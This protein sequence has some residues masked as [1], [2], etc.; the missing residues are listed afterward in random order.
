M[1]KNPEPRSVF[2]A[3]LMTHQYAMVDEDL[4]ELFKAISDLT[5]A[6]I[7]A[8][9]FSDDEPEPS[10][11]TLMGDVAY[12]SIKGPLVDH[13]DG[14]DRMMG[15]VSCDDLRTQLV[16]ARTD[17]AVSRV[18]LQVDSPG[19]MVDGLSEVVNAIKA[20]GKPIVAHVEGTC[21]SAAYWISSAC[22]AIYAAVT[23]RVG[24]LGAILTMR[25]RSTAGQIT[26]TSSQSPLKNASLEST[27]GRAVYQNVVD[28]LADVF[29]TSVALNRGI[30][31]ADVLE[32][33]G[34]GAIFAAA[35]A[36]EAGMID[37]LLGVTDEM[38]EQLK[39][40]LA[41]I[42]VLKAQNKEAT[43]ALAAE[44]ARAL[45]LEA[46]QAQAATEAAQA[47]AERDALKSSTELLTEQLKAANELKAKADAERAKV[48]AEAFETAATAAVEKLVTDSKITAAA[49][50]VWRRLY[51]LKK[52]DPQSTVFEDTAETL[53]GG[54][55][56]YDPQGHGD[57]DAP[58]SDSDKA[59]ALAKEKGISFDQAYAK[60]RGLGL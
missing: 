5:E 51:D 20:L 48:E 44:Q 13:A 11:Y 19:G 10:T 40:A 15:L 54:V 43:D 32:N 53:P 52:S 55:V 35:R 12:V 6:E 22:D 29:I 39:A 1:S 30:T 60:I 47:R 41:E 23:S 14:W 56:N 16:Q 45:E 28:D 49:R 2:I 18:V 3:R 33:Y 46:A 59:T 26:F 24:S 17:P 27:A 37:G 7:A 58:Q 31:R 57:D 38:N 21:A 8:F 36:L 9:L 25:V 4:S 34:Q 42:D 50:P